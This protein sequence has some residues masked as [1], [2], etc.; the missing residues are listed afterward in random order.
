MY[1]RL[2]EAYPKCYESKEFFQGAF[3]L[4]GSLKGVPRRLMPQNKCACRQLINGKNVNSCQ[5]RQLCGDCNIND[6]KCD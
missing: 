3:S 1:P 5:P 6:S 2:K 4:M